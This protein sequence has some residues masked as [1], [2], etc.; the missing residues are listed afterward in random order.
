MKDLTVGIHCLY[1]C[2][3]RSVPDLEENHVQIARWN[4]YKKRSNMG[5]NHRYLYNKQLNTLILIR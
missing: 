4:N 5:K 2:C 3:C 1:A